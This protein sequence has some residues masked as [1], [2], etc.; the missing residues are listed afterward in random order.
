MTHFQQFM[1]QEIS[2]LLRPGETILTQGVALDPISWGISLLYKPARRFWMTALTTQRLIAIKVK[3]KMYFRLSLRFL[4]YG[5]GTTKT[6]VR[7]LELAEIRDVKV[8]AGR[9]ETVGTML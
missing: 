4:D 2:N 6:D 1:S 9:R 8:G 5:P 7:S 3:S